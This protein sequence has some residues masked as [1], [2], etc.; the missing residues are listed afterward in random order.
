MGFKVENKVCLVTGSARGLGKEFA[1]RL[2]DKGAK[3]CIS[4]VNE[5]TGNETYKEFAKS[6]TPEAVTFCK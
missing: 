1:K 5:A 2:L 4:D 3:V 6:Y